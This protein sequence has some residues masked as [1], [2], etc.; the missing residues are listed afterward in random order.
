MVD[1][2][3]RDAMGEGVGLAGSGAGDDQERRA[4]KGLRAD[5]VFNCSPLRRIECSQIVNSRRRP[6]ESPP[7]RISFLSGGDE[8]IKN[9]NWLLSKTSERSPDHAVLAIG[10]VFR[11]AS[12]AIQSSPC[13]S[14]TGLQVMRPACTFSPARKWMSAVIAAFR[15]LSASASTN[16]SVA[17]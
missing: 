3:V 6:H 5:A 15:P 13:A 16:G 7:F 4:D 11:A 14:A 12:A 17:L 10:D 8:Q 2:E 9:G 1:N